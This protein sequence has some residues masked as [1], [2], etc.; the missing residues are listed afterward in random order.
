MEA[1]EK[2]LSL[3]SG[4]LLE[5]EKTTLRRPLAS[6]KNFAV[7]GVLSRG[8]LRLNR[9]GCPDSTLDAAFRRCA[10]GYKLN[11]FVQWNC[12]WTWRGGEESDRDMTAY[13]SRASCGWR[14]KR[15]SESVQP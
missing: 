7:G 1:A 5:G 9:A 14:D 11:L 8:I 4:L 12:S 10:S 15:K 6:S 2:D 13:K 3:H